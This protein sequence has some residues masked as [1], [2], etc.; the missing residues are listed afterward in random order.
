MAAINPLQ[1]F[2]M[3]IPRDQVDQLKESIAEIQLQETP[4]STL[5]PSINS[6][7]EVPERVQHYGPIKVNALEHPGIRRG[8]I[9]LDDVKAGEVLFKIDRPLFTS[10][11]RC[12]VN[13]KRLRVS[14]LTISRSKM[15]KTLSQTPAISAL[16]A[17]TRRA[18]L[19]R[20]RVRSSDSTRVENANSFV[21]AER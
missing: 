15:T 14:L 19:R 1:Q 2:A 11:R 8:I 17:C 16:R 12:A 13:A 20:F 9:V 10:V 6:Y 4:A 18:V 7:T 21:I 5:P 3:A